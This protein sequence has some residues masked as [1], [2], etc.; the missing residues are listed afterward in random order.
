MSPYCAFDIEIANPLPDGIEDWKSARPLGITCAATC[1]EGQQP[2]VWFGKNPDGSPSERMTRREAAEMV[3]FLKQTAATHTLLT[4]NGL[5]FDFDILAEESGRLQDCRSLAWN[6]VDMMFHVFCLKGFA[7]GLDKAAKGMGLPGKTEGM[8]GDLAPRYWKEGKRDLVLQYVAQDVRTTLD[9]ALAVDGLRKLRWIT[10]AGGS[11]DMPIPRWLT[12]REA[13]NLPEPDMSW[14]KN[15][16]KRSKFTG[17]LQ[18]EQ[19]TLF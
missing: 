7:I 2:R 10:A 8:H 1:L 15:P 11:R 9:L 5:G 16:W 13:V 4:W 12:A 17:W 14:Q 3:D 19:L 6:H 18:E